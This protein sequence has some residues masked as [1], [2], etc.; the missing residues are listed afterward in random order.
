MSL[1]GKLKD[2]DPLTT[3]SDGPLF[4]W[5]T[6]LPEPHLIQVMPGVFAAVHD[7]EAFDLVK[8]PEEDENDDA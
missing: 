8:T 3:H 1:R 4:A 7:P 5:R 6:G 2:E